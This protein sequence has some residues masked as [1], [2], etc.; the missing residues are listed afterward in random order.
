MQ[1]PRVVVADDSLIARTGIEALLATERHLKVVAS[2]AS[3]PE[4]FEAVDEHKPDVVVTDVRMPPS[5]TDE[6]IQAAEVLAGRHPDTAVVV[7]S[8]YADPTF[9]LRLVA[10]GSARRGY[11]LKD[12][13]ATPGELG[14]AIAL[15]GEGGSFID[16]AVVETL[17]CQQAGAARSAVSALT[18]RE[19]SVLA[20]LASGKSNAAIAAKLFVGERAVEKHINSIFAKLGLLDAPDVNRRVMAVLTYLGH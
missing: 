8:Q 1:G 4:L 16:P 10:Q 9:L 14:R 20:E 13:V 2:V 18:S 5:G 6:G 7:L 15:V 19:E 11:M 12:N 17:V 3:L